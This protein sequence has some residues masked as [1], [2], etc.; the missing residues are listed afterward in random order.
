MSSFTGFQ[1]HDFS[2]SVRGTHWRHR[3]AL[4]GDLRKRLRR[5]YGRRYQTWGLPGANTIQIARRAAYQ[6]PPH[7]A[8][9]A[10]FIAA[11]PEYLRW[12]FSLPTGGSHWSGFLHQLQHNA[13]ALPLLLY[14]LESLG[15][16]LTDITDASGGALGGCW[17]Y[18]NDELIWRE[19]CSLPRPALPSDI[20]FRLDDLAVNEVYPLTLFIEVDPETAMA[21]GADAANRLAPVLIA[22]VP[23]YELCVNPPNLDKP[24]P[25]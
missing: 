1:P 19:A 11:A 4:G 10:L 17:R 3:G 7:Q 13:A 16:T 5:I 24:K 14:L 2:T 23:L 6:F 25:K 20:P 9:T 15:L 22:L 18:E 12:G 21:W 8:Q